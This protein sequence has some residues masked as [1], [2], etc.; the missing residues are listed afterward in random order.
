MS[1]VFA[2]VASHAP[3]IT[4]RVLLK[5]ERC[6]L[7]LVQLD[8]LPEGVLPV[9]LAAKSARPA[10]PVHSVGN[11][12]ASGALWIYSPGRVRQVYQDKWKIFDGLSNRQMSYDSTIV[13]T[14][15]PINP[16]DSGG[17]LVNDRGSLVGIAH[18]SHTSARS[19]SVFI[20]VR[21]CRALVQRYYQSVEQR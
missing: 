3:G 11:P 18:G 21:E 20:D 9:S 14:D 2:G 5:E 6:D 13:E 12:G 7:A 8:R 15:S 16:G 1:L 19:M 17:P 4:G 10:Q